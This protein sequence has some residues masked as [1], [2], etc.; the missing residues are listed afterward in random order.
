VVSNTSRIE[1]YGSAFSSEAE[2]P[3][4]VTATYDGHEYRL[5]VR[6]APGADGAGLDEDAA[7]RLARWLSRE[8]AD[9][10]RRQ[11]EDRQ[12]HPERRPGP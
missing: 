9:E 8:A 1:I 3:C 2:A 5:K 7:Q 10:Y 6:T 11:R 4:S 12:W